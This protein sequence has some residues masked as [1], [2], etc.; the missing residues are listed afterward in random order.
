MHNGNDYDD[1]TEDN[2]DDA[3]NDIVGFDVIN[4]PKF[5]MINTPRFQIEPEDLFKTP[6][7][8]DA[9]EGMV[10]EQVKREGEPDHES[11]VQKVC[12]FYTV[13][14]LIFGGV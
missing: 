13:K 11:D 3:D 9:Q 7:I 4:T 10:V 12:R 2:D 5:D 6:K 8:A 14:C 1:D